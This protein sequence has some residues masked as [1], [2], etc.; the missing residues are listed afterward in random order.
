MS[1]QRKYN[2]ERVEKMY[3]IIDAID[4]WLKVWK[5]GQVSVK[6]GAVIQRHAMRELAFIE[7]ISDKWLPMDE[8]RGLANNELER[9]GQPRVIKPM[10]A[11]PLPRLFDWVSMP[12]PT[13]EIISTEPVRTRREELEDMTDSD[14]RNLHTDLKIKDLKKTRISYILEA[15]KEYK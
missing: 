14:I 6:V 10:P 3:E 12:F 5:A 15:E 9:L 8:L 2:E 7:Y 13:F 11:P 4:H 1:R